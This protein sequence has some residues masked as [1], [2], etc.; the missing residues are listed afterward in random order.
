MEIVG[1]ATHYLAGVPHLAAR[2][3][4]AEIAVS[5][6]MMLLVSVR[7]FRVLLH[8]RSAIA[9]VAVVG[10]AGVAVGAVQLHFARASSAPSAPVETYAPPAASAEPAPRRP[11]AGARRVP[12]PAIPNCIRV[13]TD[14]SQSTC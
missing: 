6:A 9:T 2:L 11:P 1:A 8:Y 4:I 7:F 5:L 3:W 14:P 13:L 12:R 10:M